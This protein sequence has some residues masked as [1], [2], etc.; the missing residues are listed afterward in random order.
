MSGLSDG[1]EALRICELRERL[2]DKASVFMRPQ[3][4]GEGAGNGKRWGL[5]EVA[6]ERHAGGTRAQSSCVCGPEARDGEQDP[7]R[8][9]L[10]A[11]GTA[12]LVVGV[13][14]GSR[15]QCIQSSF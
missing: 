1:G 11:D 8:E 2:I 4:S 12:W 6:S 5:E 14:A 10:H 9:E 15:A 3:V 13:A 7:G